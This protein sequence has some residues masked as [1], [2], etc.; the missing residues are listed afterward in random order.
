MTCQQIGIE[1]AP[2]AKQMGAAFAPLGDT[3]KQLAAQGQAQVARELPAQVALS[4]A[5]TAT[6]NIPGANQAVNAAI[7]AEQQRAWAQAMAEDKPLV[8]KMNK[9]MGQA[10]PQAQAMQNNQRVQ[11]LL[12][13]A[14]QKNCH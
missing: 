13:L 6:G 14:K 9:Q 7:M 2:Y 1:L 8:D 5:A 11:H 4:A 3:G 12:D 10:M